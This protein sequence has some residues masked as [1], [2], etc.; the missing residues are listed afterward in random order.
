MYIDPTFVPPEQ[1]RLVNKR[2]KERKKMAVDGANEGELK[3]DKKS[4]QKD[5]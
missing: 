1:L 3:E 2:L 4:N 5:D